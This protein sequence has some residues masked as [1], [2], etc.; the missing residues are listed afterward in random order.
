MAGTRKQI[1]WEKIEFD[2][3]AGVKSLREIG[4]LYGCTEG[5]IRKR[6]KIDKWTRDLSAR[7]EAAVR[8]KLVREEVRKAERDANQAS[9]KEIIESN[10]QA[11]LKVRL[12]HRSD[13][14]R[15]K[16][17]VSKLF[18]EVE[19]SVFVE[20]QN[21]PAETLTLPQR[22]DCVRKLTDSAKTLIA[23]EREAWGI[24]SDNGEGNV[25]LTVTISDSDLRI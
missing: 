2:Y 18:G 23:M 3:R 13:I 16:G 10:A 8:N 4:D 12:E 6:A 17:L 1:D 5:A 20:G 24:S 22:V 9:E 14:S 25:G 19:S 11:I 7:I 15:A 21:P